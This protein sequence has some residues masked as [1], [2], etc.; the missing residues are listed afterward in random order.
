MNGEI[1]LVAAGGIVLGAAAAAAAVIRGEKI[2]VGQ[3]GLIAV[4][5]LG[6]PGFIRR[7]RRSEP[8]VLISP[9]AG[10][11]GALPVSAAPDLFRRDI[12]L[13]PAGPDGQMTPARFR[14]VEGRLHSYVLREDG[15]W[16]TIPASGRKVA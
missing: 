8:A 9:A 6:A 11:T 1:S 5:L 7:A 14:V 12:A 3:K 13:R 2:S 16:G 15:S 4:T 10:P